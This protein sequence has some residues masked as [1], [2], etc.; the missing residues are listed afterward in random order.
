MPDR[1]MAGRSWFA[2]WARIGSTTIHLS[3]RSLYLLR[4]PTRSLVSRVGT[5]GRLIASARWPRDRD[6]EEHRRR[7]QEILYS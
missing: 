1:S 7:T 4:E 6:T 3:G 2:R 5:I